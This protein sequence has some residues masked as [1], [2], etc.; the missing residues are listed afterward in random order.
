MRRAIYLQKVA[1]RGK[2]DH[3]MSIEEGVKKLQKGLFAFH[4]ETGPGYKLVG[5]LLNVTII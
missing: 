3:F 1:P 4:M 2:K 5:E